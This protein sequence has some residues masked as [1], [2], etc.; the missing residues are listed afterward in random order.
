MSNFLPVSI[1][2]GVVRGATPLDARGR[3]YDTN[4]VRWRHGVLEPVGGWEKRILT[5][6][7][8]RIRKLKTWRTNAE[9]RFVLAASSSKIYVDYTGGSFDDVT[10]PD[11]ATSDAGMELYG[12]GVN[13]YGEEAFGTPR[14][15]ASNNLLLLPQYWTFGNWGEDM[16]GVSSADGRLLWYDASVPSNN[17]IAIGA[18]PTANAAVHVTPERHVMLLQAGGNA[19]RVAWCS[20][21]DTN[22]WN[23]ASTTNTAGFLDLDTQTPLLTAAQSRAGTLIFSSSDVSLM[24]YQGLPYIYGKEWLGQTRLLTPDTVVTDNGN[25]FWWAKDGFKM[26][27]GG[28][29]RTLDCPVWDY[30]KSRT[31]ESSLRMFAHGGALG[32]MPEIWWF[33]PSDGGTSIDSYVMT[34]YEEGWWAVGSLDRTAMV[35]ADAEP[36]P[37]MTGEDRILYQHESGWTNGAPGIRDVWAESNA[38]TLGAGDNFMEIKQALAANGRGYDAMTIRFY[39][40]RTPEGSEREFGPYSIRSNGWMDTRVSGR[41]VRVRLENTKNADWG[42]GELRLDVAPGAGR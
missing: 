9:A 6:L 16:L 28:S 19:R 29:I 10:P 37:L 17:F 14:S 5:P 21:E 40:N 20:R 8:T 35:G 3:W 39:A 18:A 1:P 11:L 38:L 25:V 4:L 23:F 24:R 42:I 41:D 22:D 33:Y 27:D 15:V 12:F 36:Y 26:F 31:T 13:D 2:P 7:G 30:V 32:V 34:N